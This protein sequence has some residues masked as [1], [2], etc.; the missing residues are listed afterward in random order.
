MILLSKKQIAFL[1]LGP[2]CA[3]WWI[4]GT[5]LSL[6]QLQILIWFEIYITLKVTISSKDY[7]E[8]F[9]TRFQ[10]E[11]CYYLQWHVLS[12][13]FLITFQIHVNWVEWVCCCDTVKQSILAWWLLCKPPLESISV[14]QWH[15]SMFWFSFGGPGPLRFM[16]VTLAHTA[17]LMPCCCV[18]WTHHNSN[19]NFFSK[20]PNDC[21]I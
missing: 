18:Y 14:T 19:S 6:K 7:L 20:L 10:M 9:I 17:F 1:L 3:L 5:Y 4:S 2:E 11:P 12:V 8:L 16:P 21:V 13:H 15:F